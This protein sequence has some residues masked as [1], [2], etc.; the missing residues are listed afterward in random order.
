MKEISSWNIYSKTTVIKQVIYLSE[1]TSWVAYD[2]QIVLWHCVRVQTNKPGT[3]CIEER[4]YL[5]TQ[6][7]ILDWQLSNCLYQVQNVK[8]V[9]V[10]YF[11]VAFLCPCSVA[12]SRIPDPCLCALR[13]LFCKS[14]SFSF[15][16][17]FD[18][19]SF[20]PVKNKWTLKLWMKVSLTAKIRRLPWSC[21]RKLRTNPIFDRDRSVR[22]PKT[23]VK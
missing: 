1:I 19:R 21:H 4:V 11:L 7:V 23:V 5:V 8:P 22:K 17:A 16:K 6:N 12:S 20:N 3:V 15:L 10:G 13:R 18:P 2:P 9:S 14:Y